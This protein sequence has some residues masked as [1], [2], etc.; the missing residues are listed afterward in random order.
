METYIL[1]EQTINI[2]EDSIISTTILGAYAT[3]ELAKQYRANKVYKFN[4][5]NNRDS[6]MICSGGAQMVDDGTFAHIFAIEGL[7]IHEQ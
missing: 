5:K 1:S 2:K 3:R 6:I 4:R 7:Y